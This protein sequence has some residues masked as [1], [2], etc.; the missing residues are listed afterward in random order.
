MKIAIMGYGTV[1]SGVYEV[2]VTNAAGIATRAGEAI[3]VERI[4][5]L[6]EFPDHPEAHKF[7]KNVDA[8]I[9]DKEIGLVVETMGGTEPAFTFACRAMKSGKSYVTSNKELVAAK[10]P[11]LMAL[12]EENGVSF[13]FEA[14]VGGG[15]PIIMPLKE[16]LAGNEISEIMGILNGT[17]NYILTQMFSCGASFADALSEAQKKGY[18]EANPDADVLGYDTCRKIAILTSLACGKHV[19]FSRIPTEGITGIDEIDVAFAESLRSSVKLVGYSSV[20]DGKAYCRVAPMVIPHDHPLYSVE[21][22]FN[23][24]LVTGNAIGDCMFYGRGA[25]KL[26]TASAVVSD[27]IAATTGK[28][29]IPPTWK[30]TDEDVF[31]DVSSAA[32]R[33]MIRVSSDAAEDV[34]ALF[35]CISSATTPKAPNEIAFTI[36][37]VSEADFAEKAA[38]LG[39]KLIKSIYLA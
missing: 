15:I 33:R 21:D 6:R 7:T 9:G 13:L 5:D 3:T 38:K 39:D 29:S 18:A 19:D 1:G 17:T 32:S 20:K 8:I 37:A 34:K 28:I 35:T 12:A 25:G 26:P 22:V 30:R 23:A 10:G 27:V 16:C 11:E 24:I 14:S 31:A 2:L 36:D 4:L